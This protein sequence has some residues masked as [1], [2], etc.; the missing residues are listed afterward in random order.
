MSLILKIALLNV[1]RNKRRTLITVL[2][3]MFGCVSIITYGGYIE[4]VFL[5]V[6]NG[7]IYSGTGHLQVFKKGFNEFGNI[8][9]DKYMLDQSTVNKVLEITKKYPEVKVVSRRIAFSGL[10]NNGSISNGIFGSGIEADTEEQI[11]KAKDTQTIDILSGVSL[12]S[13]QLGTAMLGQALAKR[14]DAKVGDSLTLI[15]STIDG[16]VNALDIQI[17]AI[18]TTGQSETDERFIQVNLKDIQ[19]LKNTQKVTRLTILLDETDLTRSVQKKLEQEF[20]NAGLAIEMKNWDELADFYHQIVDY[21][22]AVFMVISI[23]ILLVVIVG[24]ANT[25]T[26][27]V[28]ER[29]SELGTLRALGNNRKQLVGLVFSESIYIGI[30][31]SILGIVFGVI[32]GEII[33]AMNF[34]QSPPPQ[35]TRGYP[36]EIIYTLPLLA[37]TF[38]IGLTAAFLSCIYPALKAS[39]LKIIDALRHNQ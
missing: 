17:G 24:I 26:M 28:M 3:I 25:M 39:R 32:I 36:Y 34:I 7:I 31:G 18:V 27:A 11:K 13:D 16:A 2:A 35:C 29:T 37:K 12:S 38:V 23:I 6:R 19:M 21:Y 10:L 9:P 30:I 1:L 5:G 15:S 20:A 8:D 14:F 22:K 33:T 4:S